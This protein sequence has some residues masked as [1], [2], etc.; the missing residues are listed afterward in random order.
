MATQPK[1]VQILHWYRKSLFEFAVKSAV[2]KTFGSYANFTRSAPGFSSARDRFNKFEDIQIDSVRKIEAVFAARGDPRPFTAM[3]EEFCRHDVTVEQDRAGRVDPSW[4][5][6]LTN[7]GRPRTK[8]E[9]M[10]RG[11]AA[12]AWLDSIKTSGFPIDM[13][14]DIDTE[15][16]KGKTREQALRE[17]VEDLLTVVSYPHGKGSDQAARLLAEFGENAISQV[18]QHISTSPLGWR[19]LRV[20]TWV[21]KL[22]TQE[23]LVTENTLQQTENLLKSVHYNNPSNMYRA[24]ALWEEAILFA[25]ET[26]DHWTIEA[27]LERA[28][29]RTAS[30]WSHAPGSVRR[31][32]TESGAPVRERM[33]AVA[34]LALKLF[35]SYN[36]PLRKP[37]RSYDSKLQSLAEALSCE[38]EGGLRTAGIF[39]NK[40]LTDGEFPSVEK[41]SESPEPYMKKL[42]DLVNNVLDN[43]QFEKINDLVNGANFKLLIREACLTIDGIYRRQILE[44]LI[45]SGSRDQVSKIF[46][47]IVTDSLTLMSKDSDEFEKYRWVAEH[48]TFSVG[49]LA[50]T[51]SFEFLLNKA[52]PWPARHPDGGRAIRMTAL[53]ALGDMYSSIRGTY[54]EGQLVRAL[55]DRIRSKEYVITKPEFRA[56][57]YVLALLRPSDPATANLSLTLFKQTAEGTLTFNL[58]EDHPKAELSDSDPYLVALANWGHVRLDRRTR[59][60]QGLAMPSPLP[61]ATDIRQFEASSE[62]KLR[63]GGKDAGAVVGEQIGD[64]FGHTC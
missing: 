35:G 26:W 4:F 45:H 11:Q 7:A 63:N 59:E 55:D 64:E 44:S 37:K 25:P 34:V 1:S 46:E 2:L 29:Y 17:T 15:D 5:P 8:P 41:M 20:A 33:T 6:K 13:S 28:S 50:S 23:G 18:I 12:L 31:T 39:L 47:S 51:N 52:I 43:P 16:Q 22:S 48:A 30:E 54:K 9:A 3:F 56:A 14:G 40:T 49:F 62:E 24:R 19:S 60:W 57:L 42:F 36:N 21:L 53:L 61:G 32:E 38:S 10:L 58:A 27:L